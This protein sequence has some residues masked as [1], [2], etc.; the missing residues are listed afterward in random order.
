MPTRKEV[1]DATDT[2]E[3][4]ALNYMEMETVQTEKWYSKGWIVSEFK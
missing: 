3:H 2:L 4:D 1:L